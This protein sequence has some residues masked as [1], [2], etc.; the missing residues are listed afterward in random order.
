MF[1]SGSGVSG[2]GPSVVAGAV[3]DGNEV[4]GCKPETFGV[5][6]G[7]MGICEE[8]DAADAWCCR[9]ALA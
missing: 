8:E 1:G 3:G 7:G 4:S 5:V 9:A 6:V 2:C